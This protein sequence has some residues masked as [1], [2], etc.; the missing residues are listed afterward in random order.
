MHPDNLGK[1]FD[2][3]LAAIGKMQRIDSRFG[4]NYGFTTGSH[5]NPENGVYHSVMYTRGDRKWA[6]EMQHYDDGHV[7]HLYVN[8][9]HRAGLASLILHATGVALNHGGEAPQTGRDMTPKAEKLF[10][11]QLPTTRGNTNVA[12]TKPID[13]YGDEK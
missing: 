2:E 7:G 8:K 10:K 11:K 3:H 13:T 4:E 12:I 9:E 1:Q 5:H 6:G